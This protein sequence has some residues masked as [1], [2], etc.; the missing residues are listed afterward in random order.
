MKRT[1]KKC[2]GP[3]TTDARK[4]F[5]STDDLICRIDSEG[6]IYVTDG[7]AALRMTPAEYA[8]IIQP[9]ACREAG[10]WT[11]RGGKLVQKDFDLV[12]LFNSMVENV[13]NADAM[14]HFPFNYQSNGGDVSIFY[15]KDPGFAALYNARYI[16]A[17]APG[18]TLHALQ[19]QS[20]QTSKTA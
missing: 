7:F 11:I 16:S 6:F 1:T 2:I 4:A 15:A 18:Y 14:E 3:F 5:K 19:I 9:V 8:A 12:G 10:N 13:K 17:L 20:R